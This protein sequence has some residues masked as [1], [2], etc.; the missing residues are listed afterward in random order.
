MYYL[1]AGMI[2][3][4]K[5]HGCAQRLRD[6]FRPLLGILPEVD[7]QYNRWK[8][9]TIHKRVQTPFLGA[10][11]QN[12]TRRKRS[13]LALAAVELAPHERRSRERRY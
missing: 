9:R 2:R 4:G 1:G 5:G 13:G 8:R 3:V 6:D 10:V 11:A 7:H 12:M